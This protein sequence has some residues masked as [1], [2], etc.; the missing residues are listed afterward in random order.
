MIELET[1]QYDINFNRDGNLKLTFVIDKQYK[2]EIESLDELFSKDNIKTLKIA[3][4]RNKRSLNANNYAWKL[5]SEI[6]NKLRTSKDEVYELMLKRYGQRST[7]SVVSEA[8]QFILESVPH[9]ETYAEGTT[10]GKLFK[11]IHIY[12]G[13]SQYNTDE[14]SIFID[15]IVS[16]CKELKICTLTPLELEKIKNEWVI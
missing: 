13:S 4:K 10:N 7:I 5:M 6:G 14:M 3:K 16:E 12:K 9:A 15:G 8:E 1:K 2:Y 11:H